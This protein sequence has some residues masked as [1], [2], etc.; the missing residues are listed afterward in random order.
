MKQR[1]DLV[2]DLMDQDVFDTVEKASD[3]ILKAQEIRQEARQLD[4]FADK[5]KKEGPWELKIN[6][7]GTNIIY[8]S[9]KTTLA[10]QIYEVIVQMINLLDALHY[11]ELKDCIMKFNNSLNAITD[12]KE[13]DQ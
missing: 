1:I 5:I 7:A 9:Q 11:S 12:G 13:A 3:L 6:R 10:P 2:K 8:F 4:D